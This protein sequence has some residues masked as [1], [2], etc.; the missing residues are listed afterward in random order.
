MKQIK[1]KVAEAI[2]TAEGTA[3]K[4]A[5]DTTSSTTKKPAKG[6][7][8]PTPEVTGGSIGSLHDGYAANE[9]QDLGTA[10]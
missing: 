5:P 8:T 6:P 7:K 1:Q 10:C 9:S 4:K 2:D 3:P